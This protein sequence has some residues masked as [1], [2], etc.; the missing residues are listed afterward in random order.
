M[1][2][3]K[4]FQSWNSKLSDFDSAMNIGEEIVVLTES[5]GRLL[6]RRLRMRWHLWQSRCSGQRLLPLALSTTPCSMVETETWGKDHFVILSDKFQNKDFPPL[7]D[8][9]KN[10]VIRK[11]WDG[12]YKLVRDLL[13]ELL[14]DAGQDERVVEGQHWLEIQKKEC[15]ALVQNGL[16]DTLDRF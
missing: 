8:S 2:T 12:E 5:F 7:S 3:V 11:C 16:M 14:G 13:A 4:V 9:S 6:I 15:E 10:V 1:Q